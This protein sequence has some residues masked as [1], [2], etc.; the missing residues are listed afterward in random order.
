MLRLT[1]N[2]AHYAIGSSSVFSS[3]GFIR[4]KKRQLPVNR[5]VKEECRSFTPALIT[6][7]CAA[8]QLYRGPHRWNNAVARH[9]NIRAFIR[10]YYRSHYWQYS[11]QLQSHLLQPPFQSRN[12]TLGVTSIICHHCCAIATRRR[13]ASVQAGPPAPFADKDHP[14]MPPRVSR[15]PTG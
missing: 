10:A 14:Q 6:C 5:K 8:L 12:N 4:S 9:V 15:I 2:I 13:R 11:Q 1:L 3:C 7:R